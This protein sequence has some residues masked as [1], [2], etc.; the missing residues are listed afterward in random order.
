MKYNPFERE[1]EIQKKYEKFLSDNQHIDCF[2]CDYQTVQKQLIR[3]YTNWRVLYNVFPYKNK[4]D[5][6]LIVTKEHY[7]TPGEV[8][9]IYWFEFIYIFVF[10]VRKFK[11]F[12]V[13]LNAGGCGRRSVN[14]VHIHLA[15]ED[16]NSNKL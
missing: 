9:M 13:L 10:Y 8:P 14:H 12:H 15:V 7:E 2:F 16:T 5:H 3:E 4:T 6:I 1:E 11:D